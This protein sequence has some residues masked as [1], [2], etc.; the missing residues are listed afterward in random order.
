MTMESTLVR[1]QT[2]D[3]NPFKRSVTF[4][5]PLASVAPA[6]AERKGKGRKD[7]V[8]RR[9]WLAGEDRKDKVERRSWLAGVL[10]K[11]FRQKRKYQELILEESVISL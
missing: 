5:S 11:V 6:Q 1:A 8:E 7:K 10:G 3:R 2:V 9:S 4:A